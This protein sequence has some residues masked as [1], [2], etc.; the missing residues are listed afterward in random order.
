VV[1]AM[2]RDLDVQN[3]MTIPLPIF[4]AY[5][6]VYTYVLRAECGTALSASPF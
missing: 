4:A 1:E 6:L 2:D 3:R 5:N